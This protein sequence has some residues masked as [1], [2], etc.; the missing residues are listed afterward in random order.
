MNGGNRHPISQFYT[1]ESGL[2]TLLN[3]VPET[4]L[5]S[6]G[7]PAIKFPLSG[8]PSFISMLHISGPRSE[9]VC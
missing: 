1:N 5:R 7:S 2:T 6:D 3:M 9:G 8:N 4:G